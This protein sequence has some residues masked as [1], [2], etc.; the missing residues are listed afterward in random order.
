MP[1]KR[2]K[3]KQILVS[4]NFDINTHRLLNVVDPVDLTDGANKNY[5]DTSILNF[6]N[7]DDEPTG[8]Q[9]AERDGSTI[10]F[11]DN[12][13]TISPTG[14]SFDYYI[15]GLKYTSTGDTI[16][17]TD[18]EGTHFIYYDTD[19]VLKQ[20]T[21]FQSDIIF[22]KAYVAELYWDTSEQRIIHLGDERHG[23]VMDGK[24]H[25]YLHNKFGTTYITGLGL[26]DFTI[27]GAAASL[28][29]H[30]QFSVSNGQIW[31]ED[32]IHMI[33]DGSPQD[34]S[35]ILNCPVFYR[36]GTTWASYTGG[37]YATGNT[38]PV[39]NYNFDNV[40]LLA[41]NFNN[42]GDWSLVQVSN[43]QF[44][45]AHIFATN[46]VNNHIIAVVGQ[47]TYATAGDA[48]AGAN[49]EIGNLIT[50]G[51]SFQEFVPMATVIYQTATAYTNTPQA[52]VVQ[53][54]LGDNYVN[55]LGQTLSP[56]S[57][58]S[59]HGSLGG[60]NDD[61][62]FQYALLAGRG[63]ETLTIDTVS[64]LIYPVDTSD[65]VNL[66]YV[67]DNTVSS[68]SGGTF[69][70]T[71]YMLNGLYVSGTTTTVNTANLNISD[72]IITINS[73][74]TA[75][76]VTLGQ[77]GIKVD[78]G[79]YNPYLFIFNEANDTFRIGEATGITDNTYNISYTQAVATR[80]DSPTIGGIPY[81]NNYLNRFDTT[82]N[83]YYDYSTRELYL[84]KSTGTL[85]GVYIYSDID[86]MSTQAYFIDDGITLYA[87]NTTNTQ[88]QMDN[89][90]MV[91]S[92]NY[93]SFQGIRYGADYSG[94]Y[95]GYSLVDYTWVTTGFL[96]NGV[97]TTANN[98]SVDLGGTI[99]SGD[100]ASITCDTAVH[101]N[102]S[103]VLGDYGV[104]QAALKYSIEG[105]SASDP[106]L[107]LWAYSTAD[108][109]ETYFQIFSKQRKD[110]AATE[111][112]YIELA[113]GAGTAS[114]T[115][116]VG[117]G[118][119]KIRDYRTVK[120]G[121]EYDST[122]SDVN[123]L[124]DYSLTPKSYV[125]GLNTFVFQS[126]SGLTGNTLLNFQCPANYRVTSIIAEE[127]I[128]FNAGNISIGLS[129]TTN[130]IVNSE[131]LN[132]NDVVDLP[133]GQKFYSLVSNQDLYVN[134]TAWGSSQ[135]SLY[136]KFEKVVE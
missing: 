51:L 26:G 47:D 93:G 105:V 126:Q 9:T 86:G 90:N 34:I 110:Q 17:V 21:T 77:A 117:T 5:V 125:D 68:L 4:S 135:V 85:H 11:S 36:T 124:T 83:T 57:T 94:S 8:F 27:T 80:E 95:A 76:G 30:A 46:D 38:F 102:T 104:D 133:I 101:F 24:T 109:E 123:D 118:D 60:L 16:T 15:K 3:N 67:L 63:G 132:A 62:H 98:R 49:V 39:V 10:S 1:S 82:G 37:T 58:P 31:D 78:R 107:Y 129:A 71:V 73:G 119:F 6:A 131:T 40:N 7:I 115:F 48:R 56:T 59:D 121:I 81:W 97:G 87:N 53:T 12:Q 25:S 122:L 20:V 89:Q 45:L 66:Q 23:L 128:G 44:V 2:I 72:N 130:E 69:Q 54:D 22:R 88:F 33:I 41:Y 106:E 134:S 55:W 14:V 70:D 19:G 52:K 61:D 108:G 64:G 136:F 120:K 84:G 103:F 29:A 99:S 100:T 13:F 112:N 127:T 50:E 79:A 74:E 42:A 116:S 32:I 96:Q 91:I 35:P 65:A 111:R 114:F 113:A 43:N 92:S 18:V 75:S 28:D